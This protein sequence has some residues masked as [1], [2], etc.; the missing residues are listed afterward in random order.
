MAQ[1]ITY[2]GFHDTSESKHPDPARIGALGATMALNLGALLV[3]AM[4]MHASLGPQMLVLPPSNPIVDIVPRPL[5]PP[6]PPMPPR[7]EMAQPATA[8]PAP[9]PA[10]PVLVRED[11]GPLDVPAPPQPAPPAPVLEARGDASAGAG[12]GAASPAALR[13]IAAPA[14]PY[15]RPAVRAGL[16]GTV[17]LRVLV[18]ETGRP[19][20]VDVDQGSGHRILDDAARRQVLAHWRFQPALHDGQPTQAWGRVPI[21][22]KLDR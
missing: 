12:A 21:E 11:V 4:P 6:P 20:S 9:T 1:A 22:F 17:W 19:V 18:D 8:T 13:Y 3:L 10:A 15:P 14:P 5:P 7:P 16:T 2:R